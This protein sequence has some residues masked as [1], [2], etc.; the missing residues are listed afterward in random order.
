MGQIAGGK[1]EVGGSSPF[2]AT[3]FLKNCNQTIIDFI[4]TNKKVCT[5]G[6]IKIQFGKELNGDKTVKR[7]DIE[8][9]H[10]IL[11]YRWS[12]SFEPWRT[13]RWMSEIPKDRGYDLVNIYHINQIDRDYALKLYDELIKK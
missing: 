9:Y 6:I 2:V 3:K 11:Y 5:I 10:S 7:E 12:D 4:Y 13:V 1:L 8:A